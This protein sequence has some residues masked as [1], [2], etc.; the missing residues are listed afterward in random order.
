MQMYTELYSCIS[1]NCFQFNV[2]KRVFCKGRLQMP[3]KINAASECSCHPAKQFA[4]SL[5]ALSLHYLYCSLLTSF[6]GYRTQR[7]SCEGVQPKAH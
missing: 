1:Y 2:V 6:T 5:L 7:V 3:G 4:N